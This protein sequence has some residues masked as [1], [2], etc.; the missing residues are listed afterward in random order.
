M[1]V[2][3]V[4]M[5]PFNVYDKQTGS[6]IGYTDLVEINNH[7]LSFE[8]S[9]DGISNQSAP[10]KSILIFMVKGLFTNLQFPYT[11]FASTKLTGDSLSTV[12]GVVHVKGIKRIGLK[13]C[14]LQKLMQIV[15]HVYIIEKYTA[16]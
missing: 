6:L 12:L 5:Y 16:D 10:A 9:L 8:Q 3:F 11:Q 7:L 15:V 14:T 4:Y 2:L 13:V 1:I